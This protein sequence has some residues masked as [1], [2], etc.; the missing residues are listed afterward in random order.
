[1]KKN[2]RSK[3]FRFPNWDYRIHDT[4][5]EINI[6]SDVQGAFYFEFWVKFRRPQDI[7]L[8]AGATFRFRNELL[9]NLGYGLNGLKLP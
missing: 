7:A 1:M 9:Q 5:G 4:P 6:W 3:L 2:M 8:V